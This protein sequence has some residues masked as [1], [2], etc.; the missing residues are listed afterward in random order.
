MLEK[1]RAIELFGSYYTWS[2]RP[3][4]IED[5]ELDVLLREVNNNEFQLIN[6]LVIL[7]RLGRSEYGFRTPEE[8]YNDGHP[9]WHEHIRGVIRRLGIEKEGVTPWSITRRLMDEDKLKDLDKKAALYAQAEKIACDVREEERRNIEPLP[10][11]MRV[12]EPHPI[13]SKAFWVAYDPEKKGDAAYRIIEY[14]VTGVEIAMLDDGG[15]IPLYA[16]R[17]DTGEETRAYHHNLHME[18]D[19]RTRYTLDRPVAE[20]ELGYLRSKARM[21]EGLRARYN[22]ELDAI[23]E[24]P[25]AAPQP[26]V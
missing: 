5:Q 7:Q 1:A 17:S 11:L 19:A 3:V 16:M 23:P 6:R 24:K 22:A 13:G 25:E 12:V 8:A 21:T 15:L 20:T 2:F 10:D 4:I 9:R 14:S 26:S 18:H